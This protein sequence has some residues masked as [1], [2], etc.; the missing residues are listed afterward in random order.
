M[1]I[2]IKLAETVSGLWCIEIS[3]GSLG[4]IVVEVSAEAA[5]AAAVRVWRVANA[6]R[7]E[8]RRKLN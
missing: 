3:R 1:P 8:E 5:L 6:I 4:I 2:R 7:R